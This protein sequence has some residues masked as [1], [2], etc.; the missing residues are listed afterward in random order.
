[1]L[2]QEKWLQLPKREKNYFRPAVVNE[3]IEAGRLGDVVYVFYP[4]GAFALESERQLRARLPVFY[5]AQLL[6]Y[7]ALLEKRGSAAPDQEKW[8]E[9]HRPRAWQQVRIPKLVSVQYGDVGAFGWDGKGDFVVV[10]GYAWLPRAPLKAVGRFSVKMGLAYLALLNSPTFFELVASSSRKVR[11]GQWDL[12]NKYL[13]RVPLPNL[14]P[15]TGSPIF[16][17]LFRMGAEIHS[18][19]ELDWDELTELSKSVY[20]IET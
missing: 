1:L 12:G 15:S 13:E 17:S 6:S 16:E 7:R 8:W 20:G 5:Q 14:V 10:G 4:H 19:G 2:P 3:S 9:M 11:G 18:G